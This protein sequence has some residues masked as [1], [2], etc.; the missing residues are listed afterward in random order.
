[1]HSFLLSVSDMQRWHLMWY[2]SVLSHWQLLFHGL[3]DNNF[4]V[5]HWESSTR[6]A[7]GEYLFTKLMNNVPHLY[8]I[9][10]VRA[11]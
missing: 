9:E 7:H 2:L 11:E 3:C 8:K 5:D 6:N 1:M 4:I 10:L